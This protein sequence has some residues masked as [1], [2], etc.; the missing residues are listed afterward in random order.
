MAFLAWAIMVFDL[1]GFGNSFSYKRN[2]PIIFANQNQFCPRSV[3][4]EEQVTHTGTCLWFLQCWPCHWGYHQASADLQQ[5][6]LWK[7]CPRNLLAVP[8]MMPLYQREIKGHKWWEA[9]VPSS[10]LSTGTVM[11][12]FGAKCKATSQTRTSY[13]SA[14]M[15]L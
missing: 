12:S 11:S 9:P 6:E 4:W 10:L 5:C 15:S 14:Q 2:S 7:P 3:Q 13:Y 8:K 1:F